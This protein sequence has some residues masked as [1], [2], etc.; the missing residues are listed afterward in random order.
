MKRLIIALLALNSFGVLA[1]EDNKTI[2]PFWNNT[3]MGLYFSGDINQSQ[4][5]SEIQ[6]QTYGFKQAFNYTVG[7]NWL[8][9]FSEKVELGVDA[10]FSNKA[11]LREEVETC[12]ECDVNTTTSRYKLRYVQVPVY[13]RFY[14]YNS[15]L[16]VYGILGGQVAFN[17]SD[18][19]VRTN[20]N[21]TQH[22]ISSGA[23]KVLLGGRVGAGINYNL[24]YRYS[25]GLDLHYNHFFNETMKDPSISTTGISI[26]PNLIYKF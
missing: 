15:R 21:Q 20:Q 19:E 4:G 23:E 11:F 16:D 1:Q 8:Y 17:I 26:S 7:I 2:S 5:E 14:V 3:R 25:F 24:N 18:K 9:A 6:N 13:G 10:S 12:T 22:L